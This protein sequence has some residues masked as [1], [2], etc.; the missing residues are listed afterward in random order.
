MPLDNLLSG[1]RVEDA[2]DELLDANRSVRP[3]WSAFFDNLVELSLDAKRQRALRINNRVR[4]LGIAHDVFSDPNA[5]QQHW[6]LDLVPLILPEQ[7][8]VFLSRAMQQRAR[9]CEAILKD[10]YGEQTLLRMGLVPPELI[11]ADRKFI[12]S[13]IGITPTQARIQFM[14]VDLARQPSGAWHVIDV[15]AETLA[16][17]GYALANRM[18]HT[19]FSRQMFNVCGAIGLSRFFECVQDTIEA[20]SMSVDPRTALLTPGPDHEDY[21]SHA[22]MARYLGCDLVEGEDLTATRNG[23]L[24]KTLEGLVPVDLVIRCAEATSIDPLHFSG[25]QPSGPPGALDSYRENPDIFANALGAA[26][27]ENR[28]LA[29]YLPRVC[30]ELLGETLLIE[31]VERQWLGEPTALDDVHADLHKWAIR[32]T[33][34]ATGRPGRARSARRYSDLDMLQRREFEQDLRLFANELVA[35]KPPEF[36]MTPVFNGDG[37]SA[38]PYGMRM[39]VVAA[40]DSHLVMP[41]GLSMTV[42]SDSAAGLS[43][44]GGF[45]RDVWIASSTPQEPHVGLWQKTV[46]QASSQRSPRALQSR[47]ADNLFWLGRYAERADWLLRICRGALSGIQEDTQVSPG[48]LSCV[49]RIMLQQIAKNVPPITGV[50]G[51][52]VPDEMALRNLANVLLSDAHLV[53]G[54]QSTLIGLQ[55]TA[56]LSRHRLSSEAWRAVHDLKGERFAVSPFGAM[57][58]GQEIDLLEQGLGHIAAFNGLMHENMTRN[59]GWRFL[60]M[61]RRIER[62]VNMCDVTS[63]LF[64][65]QG[66][67]GEETSGLRFVLELADSFMT[68]RARYRLNLRLELVLDLLLLDENN[69]R[70]LAYQFS[71]IAD[72]L[73]HLPRS[74]MGTALPPERRLI[75]AMRTKTQTEIVETLSASDRIG[76]AAAVADLSAEIPQLSDLIAR[77]YFSLTSEDSLPTVSYVKSM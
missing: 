42:D 55:R 73:E 17:I 58:I 12:Q 27:V 10:L 22:Y 2:Y 28:G 29:C 15:H 32:T 18:A 33:S 45:T 63:S 7:D 1:Y 51:G 21:F 67:P 71:Q 46:E 75:M 4:E 70:S 41:G 69:P 44:R 56:E 61:G 11:Y 25:M 14:A 62:A 60:D 9:L 19:H 52:D 57:N 8:W 74:D 72:H 30:Q 13:L 49:R 59:F 24:L 37:L 65:H 3:H 54:I 38:V 36:A 43:A 66:T 50:W 35:E 5:S 20:R 23:L 39:F 26:V 77:R 6:S 34:E 40:G 53:Q 64:K 31:D 48:D 47:V 76:T 68:Y 16:G